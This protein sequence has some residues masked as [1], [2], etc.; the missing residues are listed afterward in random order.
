M[1]VAAFPGRTLSAL[2][3]NSSGA[4][5]EWRLKL[6]SGR[7]AGAEYPLVPGD[8][9]FVVGLQQ[10]LLS[11]AASSYASADNVVFIPDEVSPCVFVV[12]V[13]SPDEQLSETSPVQIA[14]QHDDGESLHFEALPLQSPHA[15]GALWLAVCQHQMPWS[16][17][18]RDF[19]TPK[20]VAAGTTKGAKWPQRVAGCAALA[21][22]LALG[23]I[24]QLGLFKTDESAVGVAA[25]QEALRGGPES[26]TILAGRDHHL[27]VFAHHP[28]NMLWA[29]RAVHSLPQEEQA[30]FVTPESEAERVG[31]LLEAAG[32][33]SAVIAV[34]QP[35]RPMV[36][37]VA[38]GVAA[39][40][41]VDSTRTL[42]MNAMPYAQDV[43]VDTIDEQAL[44]RKAQADLGA[45]GISSRI[46]SVADHVSVMND[47]VLADAD[48]ASMLSYRKRFTN[49]WGERLVSI[50]I[51]LWDDLTKGQSY[52]YGPQQLLTTEQ[53]RW[54][55]LSPVTPEISM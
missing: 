42:L 40:S 46:V 23:V 15:L 50:R 2:M 14:L 7:I 34:T 33:A 8:T 17:S 39:L 31:H 32:Q 28:E 18:V 45:L 13:A 47:V 5:V 35:Q 38:H 3:V 20:T 51:Q 22:A 10:Q 11:G 53:G 41:A 6:L 54:K 4:A 30:V 29:M 49:Q 16:P 55:F 9:V 1:D 48:L 36:H 12:R 24:W 19:N 37:V 21:A 25:L 26:F 43:T 27:Y 44:A 52:E